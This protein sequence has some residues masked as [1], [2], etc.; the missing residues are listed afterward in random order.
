ME[1]N[2]RTQMA[3]NISVLTASRLSKLNLNTAAKAFQQ[4]KD[5]LKNDNFEEEIKKE[6]INLIEETKINNKVD[7]ED[8]QKYANYMGENLSI[9]DIN[10]GLMYGR[11]VIADYS[12]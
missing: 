9:D 8:I 2:N 7:V 4:A 1:V 10:Y 11:S 3:E 6:D 12:A 5:E